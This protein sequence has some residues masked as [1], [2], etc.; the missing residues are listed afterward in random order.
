MDP[1]TE[2]LG[3]LI[4]LHYQED[5]VEKLKQ[6]S[7]KVGWAKGWPEKPSAFWNG[8]A[9]LWSRKI[10]SEVREL[11]KRRVSF[12]KDGKNLDLGGGAYSYLPSTC[13][14]FS[15]KM[16]RLND[17]CLQ[18]IVG[19]L[20][21]KLPFKEEEFDSVTAIFVLNY[22]KNYTPLLLEINRV[23]VKNGVF[24]M[25]LGSYGVNEWQKQHQTTDLSLSEWVEK[26]KTSHFDVRLVKSKNLSFF[27]C[28]KKKSY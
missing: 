4:E 6:I 3:G 8:E 10:P 27:I 1:E 7:N 24:V 11:I 13:Y 16:L 22:I 21:K 17:N 25:V 9:F 12:L 19:D 15:E 14:D 2:F 26:I 28:K 5:V 20:E 18:G 23:L